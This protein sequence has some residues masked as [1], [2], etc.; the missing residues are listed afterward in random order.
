MARNAPGK[1]FRKGM[2]VFE[3][4]NMFP[5]D[6]AA[7]YWFINNRWKGDIECPRCGSH[8]VQE[9][10]KHPTMR[11]RCRECRKFFSVKT[12]TVM[13]YSNLGYQV[14][15]IA[16]YLLTTSLKGV[17]S[18]KLHRDL[19]IT[20]KAAWHLAHRIRE[21]YAEKDIEMLFGVVEIDETYIGGKESNK[22]ESK[23]QNAGRGAVGKTPVVG[24]KA[25][26]SG[27]IVAKPIECTDR[28]TLQ[29]FIR[30][31][32]APGATVYTD[33]HRSYHGLMHYFHSE[34]NHSVGEYVR[35]MAHTNGIE[36]FWAVFK[37]SFHG[38]FHKMGKKHLHRYVT[39]FAGK[40]NIRGQDTIKQMSYIATGMVGKK[41]RY[42]DLVKPSIVLE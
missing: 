41:L 13:E 30:E 5:D 26:E 32:V 38:T 24:G 27:K 7:E 14:W 37:R 22:H 20:Q 4:I 39:E 34:V 10:T 16:I 3:L 36:S 11:H 40:H 9:Q 35:L 12:G 1:Y 19:G 28:Q 42:A 15:A 21:T 33:G 25:R 23:R 8:N 29:G 6:T 18:M 31:T 17:S 2:T